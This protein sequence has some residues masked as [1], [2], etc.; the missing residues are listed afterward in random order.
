MRQIVVSEDSF[1][2]PAMP[3]S[4]DHRGVIEFVRDQDTVWVM[5]DDKLEIRDTDIVFRDDR[6]AYI[7][8]GLNEGEDVVTSTLATVASRGPTCC[9][10]RRRTSARSA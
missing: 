10:S 7:R 1:L 6:Y 4:G 8:S 2:G 9:C 5:K 3:D